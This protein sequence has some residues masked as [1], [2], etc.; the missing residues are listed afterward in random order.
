MAKDCII[1]SAEDGLLSL[2][3][4]KKDIPYVKIE[5]LEDMRA[6]FLYLRDEKHKYKTLVIDSLTE[7]SDRIKANIEKK[8]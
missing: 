7:I 2:N 3:A 1:A 6:L 5:S 4:F 8:N